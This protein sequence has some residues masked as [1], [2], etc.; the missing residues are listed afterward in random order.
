MVGLGNPGD[1]YVFTRH[2]IGFLIL[3]EYLS[4]AHWKNDHR[5]LIHKRGNT[6]FCKPMTF[7]NL[8]GESVMSLKRYFGI[9]NSD[10]LVVCDDLYLPEGTFKFGFNRNSGGHN[11]LK[12]IIDEIGGK[13]F[14]TLRIGIGPREKAH[15]IADYVL[16]NFGSESMSRI[17]SIFP[18]IFLSIKEFEEGAT[19]SQ[20][21]NK[22][23]G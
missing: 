5:G 3:D 7:M 14:C 22:Y 8:S 16:E 17:K 10:I 6:M 20:L 9:L 19:I 2:N 23:N 4:G 18:T 13:D 15:S 1:K 12:N 11:G 21:Q